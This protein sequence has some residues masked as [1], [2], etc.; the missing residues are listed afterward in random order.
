MFFQREWDIIK[1]KKRARRE[2]P[3][4]VRRT[5]GSQRLRFPVKAKRK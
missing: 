2:L 1:L 3:D 5:G 4:G